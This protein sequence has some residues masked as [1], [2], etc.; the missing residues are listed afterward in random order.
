MKGSIF[1]KRGL[2]FYITFIFI[3]EKNYLLITIGVNGRYPILLHVVTLLQ[4][5]TDGRNVCI[6]FDMGVSLIKIF[7]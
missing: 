2:H 4:K 3:N 5:C 7:F 1:G 6:H